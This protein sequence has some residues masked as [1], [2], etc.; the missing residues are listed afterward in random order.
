MPT[1]PLARAKN[2]AGAAT[3]AKAKSQ[4]AVLDRRVALK[5]MEMIVHFLAT[6]PLRPEV[7]VEFGVEGRVLTDSAISDPKRQWERSGEWRHRRKELFEGVTGAVVSASASGGSFVDFQ[8]LAGQ[9]TVDDTRAYLYGER[10]DRS[11]STPVEDEG[12]AESTANA[13]SWRRWG[14]LTASG[15]TAESVQADGERGMHLDASVGSEL[16]LAA[17]AA[18]ARGKRLKSRACVRIP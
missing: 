11:T 2:K 14:Y 10:D 4:A 12:A 9:F 1:Q 15:V 6:W 13:S 18:G 7:E 17:N 16:G 5:R 8:L 3:K